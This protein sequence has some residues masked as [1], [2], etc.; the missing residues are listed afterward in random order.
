MTLGEPR[1][2]TSRKCLQQWIVCTLLSRAVARVTVRGTNDTGAL[3]AVVAG[4]TMDNHESVQRSGQLAMEKLVDVL[5]RTVR[6]DGRHTTCLFVKLSD[7][8]IN[9]SRVCLSDAPVNAPRGFV[10]HT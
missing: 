7:M 2:L 8:P 10:H 9:V 4:G 3:L 1:S 5:D 6:E